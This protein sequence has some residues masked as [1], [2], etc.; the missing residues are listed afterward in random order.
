MQK[1]KTAKNPDIETLTLE[2]TTVG[3]Y[4]GYVNFRYS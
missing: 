2:F 4:A 1:I 3:P